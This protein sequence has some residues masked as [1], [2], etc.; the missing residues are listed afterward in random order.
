[1]APWDNTPRYGLRSIVHTNADDDAFRLWLL[2]ALMDTSNRYAPDEQIVFLHS[3]NEWC[4]GTYV[5]PDGRYGRRRL[6]ETKEAVQQFRKVA[7]LKQNES[8]SALIAHLCRVMR[9]KD[10]GA[11]RSLQAM[12]QQTMHLYRE[13]EN[14]RARVL[15]LT[16]A[17]ACQAAQ[18]AAREVAV[19]AAQDAA[20][21]AATRAAEDVLQGV[22]RSKSW[23]LT[24]PLRAVANIVKKK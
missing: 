20:E 24:K 9:Q 23:R 16:Q 6:E 21:Q 8:D 15:D 22:Y 12:R 10:L 4:E 2:Q 5:E 14:Q 17:A 19:Q 18:I 1:M 13:L 3:W 7:A 11:A